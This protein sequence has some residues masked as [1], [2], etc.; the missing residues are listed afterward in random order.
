MKKQDLARARWDRRAEHYDKAGVRAERWAIGDSREWVCAQARGRTLE[1]AVGTGRNLPLYRDDVILTGVDL[2]PGMLAFARQ[3]AG[4]L[5]RHVELREAPA[6]QLP[7]DDS[8]FDTVVCTLA[9][10]AVADRAAAIAEMSRVL[11]P[12]GRLLLLDHL[13]RRWVRGR[14][15]TLAVRQGLVPV[16]RERLRLGVIERLAARKPDRPEQPDRPERL[17]RVEEPGGPAS[18]GGPAP[19]R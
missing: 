13:E 2:S 19:E 8:S 17:D 5:G 1:V 15:A 3:R 11:R 9:V 12:G 6:E 7:F 4:E 14:P 16:L 18:G 10:C